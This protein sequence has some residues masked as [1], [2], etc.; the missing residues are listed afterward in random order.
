MLGDEVFFDQL[1]KELPPVFTREF[2]SEKIGRI[3]SAKSMSNADALGTDPTV[4]VKIGKKIGYERDSFI[5]CLR[6]KM[7]HDEPH[8]KKE[9]TFHYMP[10]STSFRMF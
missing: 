1:R 9:N 8:V 4:K 2:A 7:K 10:N 5:R 3:F 6:G